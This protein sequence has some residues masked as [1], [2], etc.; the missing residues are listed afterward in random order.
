MTK[1][2]PKFNEKLTVK[3]AIAEGT[4]VTFAE[5]LRMPTRLEAIGEIVSAILGSGS[6]IAGLLVGPGSAGGQPDRDQEQGRNGRPPPHE[7]ANTILKRLSR[8]LRV[9]ARFSSLF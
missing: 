7:P 5:A 6:A 8:L 3:G 4:P 9:A 2:D 1:K